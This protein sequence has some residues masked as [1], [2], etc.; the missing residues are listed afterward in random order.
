MEVAELKELLDSA[1]LTEKGH[2]TPEVRDA[3]FKKVR[4]TEWLRSNFVHTV[5][6]RF[7]RM[8]DRTKQIC[9]STDFGRSHGVKPSDRQALQVRVNQANRVCFDCPARNP[10]WLS[11]PFGAFVCTRFRAVTCVPLST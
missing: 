3:F 6:L 10:V 11:L 7:V 1:P 4:R 2:V 5:V 8:S 9:G